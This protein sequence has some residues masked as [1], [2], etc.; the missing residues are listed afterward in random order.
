M[1]SQIPRH[2]SHL[3]QRLL[4]FE[5]QIILS[6]PDESGQ[7]YIVILLLMPRLTQDL[8]LLEALSKDSATSLIQQNLPLLCELP[9]AAF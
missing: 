1:R 9:D 4:I 3:P 2:L 6:A 5:A 8:T 7:K